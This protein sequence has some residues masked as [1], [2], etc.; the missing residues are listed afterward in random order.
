[1]SLA[2]LNF[3]IL[4]CV[5]PHLS[6]KQ[7]LQISTACKAF[8]DIAVRNVLSRGVLLTTI[9]QLYLFPRFILAHHPSRIP[10]LHELRVKDVPFTDTGFYP[11]MPTDEEIDLAFDVFARVLFHLLARQHY[12]RTIS[13]AYSSLFFQRFPPLRAAFVRYDGLVELELDGVTEDVLRVVKHLRSNLRS[14]SLSSVRSFGNEG[15]DFGPFLPCIVTYQQLEK[16]SLTCLPNDTLP[17]DFEASF[18]WP[19]VRELQVSGAAPLDTLVAAFPNVRSVH[20]SGLKMLVVDEGFELVSCPVQ[21]SGLDHLH[22]SSMDELCSW[23]IQCPVRHLEWTMPL[24]SDTDNADSDYVDAA[25]WCLYLMIKTNPM[26]VSGLTSFHDTR[27]S[28]WAAIEP[29]FQ[30]VKLLETSVTFVLPCA[31]SESDKESGHDDVD[32]DPEQRPSYHLAERRELMRALV[33]EWIV[34]LSSKAN[35]VAIV[36]WAVFSLGNGTTM[37][38]PAPHSVSMDH[39]HPTALPFR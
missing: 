26:I 16:L 9:R 11:R 33:G 6:L 27:Q 21:W 17:W 3:D 10:Y 20:I 2:T 24:P 7:A 31:S 30:D 1:M 38:R 32:V 28:F 8:R 25:R 13:L 15:K 19:T 18:Q 14:L 36:E 12:L 5:L 23:G 39:L 37:A 4:T 22:G 35:I 34:S 29:A